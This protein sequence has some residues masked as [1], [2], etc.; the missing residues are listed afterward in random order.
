MSLG[1]W[2]ILAVFC[3][4]PNIAIIIIACR[5]YI[6]GR[7]RDGHLFS[8]FAFLL[9]IV[10]AIVYTMLMNHFAGVSRV[11]VLPIA[12][13]NAQQVARAA[14]VLGRLDEQDFV[15][16]ARWSSVTS[17]RVNENF[18]IMTLDVNGRYFS[19][20]HH[21]RALNVR[22]VFYSSDRM[23]IR[24]IR[25]GG[26][27][28]RTGLVRLAGQYMH[29]ENENGTEVFLFPPHDVLGTNIFARRWLLRT[30]IRVGNTTITVLETLGRH[31]LANDLS[32][33]FIE[34]IVELIKTE[35]E[36]DK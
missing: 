17:W 12:Q 31:N 8:Y 15:E 2:A 35:V 33:I 24:E 30:D 6:K 19:S 29:I 28:V 5:H 18:D 3:I 16:T 11:D 1:F 23:A 10:T 25:Y 27:G 9:F 7:V 21:E 13:L 34:Y 26:D 32:N 22:V 14:D 4:I 36:Y 20:R